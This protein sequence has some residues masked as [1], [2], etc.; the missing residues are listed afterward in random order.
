MPGHWS[1]HHPCSSCPACDDVD[2]PYA[3]SDFFQNS[4][5]E[6]RSLHRPPDGSS[7]ASSRGI[8]SI[9]SSST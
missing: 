3:W 4:T 7:I 8:V 5:M 1:S 2:S 9:E 6:E